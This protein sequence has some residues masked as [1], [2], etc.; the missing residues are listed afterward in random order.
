MIYNMLLFLFSF[1]WLCGGY[2]AIGPNKKIP[3][4]HLSLTI[5]EGTNKP[6]VRRDLED[7]FQLNPEEH[8]ELHPEPQRKSEIK[9]LGNDL[10]NSSAE[11]KVTASGLSDQ[12]AP[13]DRIIAC[14]QIRM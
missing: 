8:F 12:A 7:M 5:K 9:F 10:K 3:R 6:D 1:S 2:G 13:G 4:P 11:S 14:C